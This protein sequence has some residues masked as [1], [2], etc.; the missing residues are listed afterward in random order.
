MLTWPAATRVAGNCMTPQLPCQAGT[1]DIAS[2]NCIDTVIFSGGIFFG[3]GS[4]CF[5][6]QRSTARIWRQKESLNFFCCAA[7]TPSKSQL[8]TRPPQFWAFAVEGIYAAPLTTVRCD[9]CS[10][11]DRI[12]Q[13]RFVRRESAIAGGGECRGLKRSVK[14]GLPDRSRVTASSFYVKL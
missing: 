4:R 14:G 5:L 2:G 10:G 13:A 9:F 1:S 3:P 12:R 7:V 6:T 8:A 11:T